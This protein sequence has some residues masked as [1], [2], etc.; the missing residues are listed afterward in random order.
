MNS[1]Q[2][3]LASYR[4]EAPD[5]C[6]VEYRYTP[7]GYYEH[8]EKLNDLFCQYVGDYDPPKRQPIPQLGPECFDGDGRYHEF[9][10]D[11][12]GT[13]WEYRIFGIAGIEKEYPL[14]DWAKLADY[15]MPAQPDWV[16]D[17][18]AYQAM[19]DMVHAH[20]QAGY[21]YRKLGA[22]K[23]FE[24]L[25]AM[26]PFEDVLCDL[27]TD[28][29]EIVQLLD[30]ICDYYEPQ[31]EALIRMGVDVIHF[32]DDFGTQTDLILSPEIFKNH[33]KPRYERLMR[34]IRQAGINVHFHSCGKIDRLFED[35]KQVGVD[36]IWPQV[37]AYDMQRLADTLR[38]LQMSIAIHTDRG[39][40]MTHGT[41]EQV[42]DLVKQEYNT[43]RPDKGGAWYYIEVDNGMP[44]ENVQALVEEV[45]SYR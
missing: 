1:R 32:G 30:M 41:P 7:V 42:R 18:A 26:R 28:E 33:F 31:I 10:R 11:A 37:P 20:Q 36:S 38:D 19:A 15:K 34:P 12:W 23:L 3:V 14:D 16:T 24:R 27:F 2:R 40:V 43:F 35:L 22:F 9:K 4:F 29:D 45:F 6:P 8:G 44:F 13:L 17:P 39:G 5:A 21:A 25:I